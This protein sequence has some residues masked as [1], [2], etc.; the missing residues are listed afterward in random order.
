[1]SLLQRLLPFLAPAAPTR[2]P[3]VLVEFLADRGGLEQELAALRA[4]A[5]AGVACG[6]ERLDDLSKRLGELAERLEELRAEVGKL[7]REQ[8]R[9]A[10]LLEGHGANLDELAEA[11]HEHLRRGEQEAADVRRALDELEGQVRLGTARELLPLAD[12]LAE[13]V[14]AARQLLPTL[15]DAPVTAEPALLRLLGVRLHPPTVGTRSAAFEAWLAG[16]L[17]VEQRLLAALERQGVRPIPALGQPF[18]PHLHLAVG[19]ERDGGVPDGIVV[20][21]DR[22]GFWLG[23]RVLRHAEVVVARRGGDEHDHRD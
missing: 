2:P 20:R 18:D 12:A 14:R 11:W 16:L 10:T 9:A 15:R 1:M 5:E 3:S 7:G 21:E 13:S 19:V 23:E 8:F 6:A 4:E 17:L 22:R